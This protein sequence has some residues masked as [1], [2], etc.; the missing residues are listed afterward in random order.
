MMRT[1]AKEFPFIS[2]LGMTP[3]LLENHSYKQLTFFELKCQK[4]NKEYAVTPDNGL[5]WRQCYLGSMLTPSSP[6]CMPWRHAIS[7]A[8][9]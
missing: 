5:N 8:E 9:M 7:M 4:C 6:G 2:L 3:I 1:P